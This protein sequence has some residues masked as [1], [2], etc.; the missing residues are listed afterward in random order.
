[1]RE[2]AQVTIHS[3]HPFMPAEPDRS[4]VR[5]FRGRLASPVTLWTSTHRERPAGL[6]VSSVL[7]AD[8]EPG[9]LVGILD[10]LSDLWDALRESGTAVVTMLDWQHRQLADQFGYVAPAPGG[11]FAS[12][13]WLETR[14]GP[15][16]VGA[17]AWAGCRLVDPPATRLGWGLQVQLEVEHVEIGEDSPPLIHRRGRYFQ[18]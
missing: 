9:Y 1:V 8:G 3:E 16:L 12:G 14:W 15:S 11:P 6:T 7:V 5:R 10:P 18:L 2:D 17:S 4:P 13:D